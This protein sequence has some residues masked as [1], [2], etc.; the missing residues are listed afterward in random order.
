[1]S[2]HPEQEPVPAAADDQT[3]APSDL[4]RL[5]AELAAALAQAEA[6]RDAQL[7][8]VAEMD[9]V[10][11]RAQRD[12]ES[13][14][15]YAIERFGS[16]MV[17]VRDSLELGLQAAAAAPEAGRFAEGMQATLRLLDKAFERAGIALLD[18]SGEA[19][20]PELHEA[21]TLQPSAEA[22]PGSV[23]AVIQKGFTL[24][25]RLLRPARVVVARAP[26]PAN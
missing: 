14:H 4:E 16:D 20:N 15:R 8:A 3:A 21:M 26:D 22:A 6:A 25:G 12:V 17:E 23:L 19:F 2:V 1:M 9:N 7:R 18:P 10:R 24:N 5:A 13:A 11:K